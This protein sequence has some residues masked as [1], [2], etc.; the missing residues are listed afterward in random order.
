[1]KRLQNVIAESGLTLPVAVLFGLV[2][3]LAGGLV[4]R[5]L[6]PQLACY[7]AAVYLIV[8]MSNRHALLRVRSR[9]VSST[10]IMMSCT[11][12][13]IF[14]SLSS[15]VVL[16]CIVASFLL[17][18]QTYQVPW[19]VGLVFYA[20][21]PI[22]VASFF[23]VQVL[24]YVPLLWVLMASQLQ[25][26]S[27]R[28]WLASIIG[29]LAPYWFALLWFV[30]VRDFTPL[31]MHFAQLGEVGV[32]LPSYSLSWLLPMFFALVL[33]V[34][35]MLHFWQ[36]SYEDKIRIRLLYGLFSTLLLFTLVAVVLQPQHYKVLM[37]LCFFFASP[38]VAHLF[39]FIRGRLSNIL[40]FVVIGIGVAIAAFNLY[41][42]N[43]EHV[44][45]IH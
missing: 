15:M 30:Y 38:I 29:L 9:M 44:G 26:F 10:F 4:N 42:L 31:A 39:T 16:L 23:F 19:A 40:F 41:V 20:F 36:Y 3:W 17:L 33:S 2:V 18:L 34:V 32:A 8:E 7:G 12:P 37:P 25:S 22:G 14:S 1:M 21:V 27:W 45:R 35:G 11:V 13:F 5:N 28:T 24:W 43:A 6:W